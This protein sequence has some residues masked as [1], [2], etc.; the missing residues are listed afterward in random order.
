[1]PSRGELRRS[2]AHLRL[3]RLLTLTPASVLLSLRSPHPR[4]ALTRTTA[5]ILAATTAT[6]TVIATSTAAPTAAIAGAAV[7]VRSSVS[8]H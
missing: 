2:L 6:G 1:M 7:Y 8:G 4:S 3:P 5:V